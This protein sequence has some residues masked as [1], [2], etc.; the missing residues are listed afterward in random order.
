MKMKFRFSG[1]E[2][3]PCRYTW[4]PKG[5]RELAVNPALFKDEDNAMVRLGVGKNMVRSIRFWL[6]AFG[7]AESVGRTQE[8]RL[9]LFGD[10]IFGKN[11]L[12]P[13][14]EDN[15]TLWL[16]HWQISSIADEPLFAWYFLLNQ[17]PE[18]MFSKTEIVRAFTAESEK[19]DRP[20]SD[21]TKD[22]HFDIFLHSYLS[23]RSRKQNDLLEDTL[24]CPLAELD[25]VTTA[26]ERV[27][28]E[29]SRK[30]PLYEF[31]QLA[32]PEITEEL[33]I[34]CLYD[35]W[36]K[37]RQQESSLSFQ[38]ISFIPGSIGQIFKLNEPDIRSRLESLSAESRGYFNYQAS[39]S[40]PKVTR[41]TLF[42]D[43]IE[44][45]LLRRIFETHKN[46]EVRKTVSQ[47]NEE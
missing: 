26:G 13:F 15:K 28:G 3:F 47:L 30:E 33:F 6:Q 12:D 31:R 42:S 40:T 18:P 21:F 9:T 37:N 14:L 41:S 38:E 25:L 16:L 23:G 34:F 45:K 36:K 24:D 22:Q 8:M 10:S 46:A 35:F 44:S 19:M 20:L 2:S 17:W 4:L 7:I 5:Y 29:S 11:G 1:H 43:E 27:L 39:A 32:K